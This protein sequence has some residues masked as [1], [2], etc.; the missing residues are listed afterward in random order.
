MNE[1]VK[2]RARFTVK[3]RETE[4]TINQGDVVFVNKII[5]QINPMVFVQ[6]GSGAVRSFPVSL[7]V[8]ELAFEE[9]R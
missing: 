2:F 8:F 7:A 4:D 3:D 1:F 9:V 5:D 6:Y